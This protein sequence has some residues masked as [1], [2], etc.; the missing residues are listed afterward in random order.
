MF[1]YM[2][3]VPGV[4]KT[5][6]ITDLEILSRKRGIKLERMIGT[7][8]LCDLSG[9]KNVEELRALPEEVRSKYRLKL[10]EIIYEI[11]RKD[12]GTIRVAD[13]HF[14]Y[15]DVNGEKYGIRSIYPWDKQQLLAMGVVMAEP[16]T[17]LERRLAEKDERTDRQ[18]DLDFITKE[19]FIELGVAYYQANELSIP[20]KI[21]KN[22]KTASID[23]TSQDMLDFIYKTIRQNGR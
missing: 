22:E 23:K 9:A 21:F 1:I 14:C 20:I 5:T 19:Q 3:G 6:L 11:D 17:I 13:G 8:I 12:S 16:N 4:G 18:L 7:K 15:F 10:N 2:G